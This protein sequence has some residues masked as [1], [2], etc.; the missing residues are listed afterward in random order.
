MT[1]ESS[2]GGDD[3]SSK[4]GL[5][6]RAPPRKPDQGTP[7]ED[8]SGQ[9][10]TRR[11]KSKRDQRR[12]KPR[13]G[14]KG[15][16]KAS[17][18]G[19]AKGAAAGAAG[20]RPKR[21][22]SN[23]APRWARLC[24]TLG[25]VLVV[26]AGGGLGAAYALVNRYDSKIDRE[27]LLPK[28]KGPTVPPTKE[29]SGPMNVLVVGVDNEGKQRSYQGIEGKR[30]DTVMLFH[31]DRN[32]KKAYAVSV[33]RDSAVDIPGH[34]NDKINAAVQYGGTPLLIQTV[35]NLLN[36]TVDHV[37]VVNFK[38]LQT[39]TDAVGGVDVMIDKTVRDDRS[40]YVFPKGKN[41]LNGKLAEIYVRQRYNL[42][43]SDYDRIKRQQQ[44]LKALLEKA[45]STGVLT[46]PVKLDALLSAVTESLTVD[47][48]FPVRD[49]AFALRGLRI[50]DV[51]F[52]TVPT[53]GS[54]KRN[55]QDFELVS[56]SG[57]RELGKALKS[58]SMPVYLK[59]YPPNN[60][61]HGS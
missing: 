57:V 49:L 2:S 41:H 16:S 42:P 47:N 53:V 1:S 52:S 23:R 40:H 50:G 18:K 10:K 26:M 37:V 33:P 22:K 19:A 31:L 14:S 6:F 9:G 11:T 24:I 20:S 55:G 39:V 3:G 29:V 35:Q 28:A 58:D 30:S 12:D 45:T 15:G 34:G 7:A 54:E 32:L 27:D 51:T 60:V 5:S 36:I 61:N 43:G 25:V 44:F 13:R 48:G 46:N 8:E 21:K 4:S 56:E 38:G 59:K 17:S